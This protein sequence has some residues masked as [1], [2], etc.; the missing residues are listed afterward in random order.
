MDQVLMLI[1]GVDDN[2]GKFHENFDDGVRIAVFRVWLFSLFSA[3]CVRTCA[4]Y[5]GRQLAEGYRDFSE[6]FEN[7]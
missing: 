6:L 3:R 2:R 4:C 1:K 7:N 5:G